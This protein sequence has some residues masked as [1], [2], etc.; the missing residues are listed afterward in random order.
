MVLVATTTDDASATNTSTKSTRSGAAGSTDVRRTA[1]RDMVAPGWPGWRRWPLLAAVILLAT[2][3]AAAPAT[4]TAAID[5]GADGWTANADAPDTAATLLARGQELLLSR[6]PG[7]AREASLLFDAALTLPAPSAAARIELLEEA[8]FVRQL[9]K[10][11]GRALAARSE[12]WALTLEQSAGR[13][14][15]P[16]LVRAYQEMAILQRLDGQH[17]AALGTVRDAKVRRP[18]RSTHRQVP[19]IT[20]LTRLTR[21]TAAARSDALPTH[22]STR[23]SPGAPRPAHAHDRRRGE[24]PP[25][26]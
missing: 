4:R 5:H 10:D 11:Y 18:T 7:G 13:T 17:A 6:G 21:L 26:S 1:D 23:T 15:L 19:P 14:K 12:A 22:P 24:Q 16:V 9:A 8:S 2:I 25:L 3:P 20:R